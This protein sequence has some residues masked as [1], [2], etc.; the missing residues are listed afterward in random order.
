MCNFAVLH[1]I[2]ILNSGRNHSTGT[3]NS[4]LVE[5]HLPVISTISQFTNSFIT[6]ISFL[7]RVPVLS[8]QI[9]LTLQR[10]STEDKRRTSTFF[11]TKRFTHN[12]ND[13]VTTAGNHSG[14]AATAKATAAKNADW[15]SKCETS[16]YTI[17]I[18]K[19][20]ITAEIHKIFDK[21]SNFFSSVV[22]FLGAS[23][24]I[25]AILHISVSIHI[26]VIT[27]LQRHLVIIVQLNTMFFISAKAV[28]ELTVIICFSTGTL[29]QVNIDSSTSKLTT[30]KSLASAGILS[31]ASS[32]ITSQIV[33]SLESIKTSFQSLKTFDFNHAIFLRDWIALSAL[34]SWKNHSN[35]FKITTQ[36]IITASTFSQI[37]NEAIAAIIRI[38]TR[39]DVNW[40]KN[41]FKA[42]L[43]SF[44]LIIFLPY[45]S[46]L[47]FASF[48][49]IQLSD[50][51]NSPSR[52]E[53]SIW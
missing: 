48:L 27:A 5:Y 35:A 30:S 13:I 25:H 52:S 29:S 51:C 28:A 19:H 36:Q 33:N 49:E 15:N 39:G 8:V 34:Y 4:H 12:H 47:L 38:I 18:I 32:K 22:D 9:I 43:L 31:Q 46:F 37:K 3:E 17:K 23:S 42:E 24:N 10:V 11:L 21:L 53:N 26:A 14:I 40:D 41:I 20:I 2:Q 50:V 6:V 16:Q 7:V 45:N 1:N 44:D